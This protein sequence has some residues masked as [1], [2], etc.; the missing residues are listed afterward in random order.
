MYNAEWPLTTR[1]HICTACTHNRCWLSK[2]ERSVYKRTGMPHSLPTHWSSALCHLAISGEP[3][4][5]AWVTS[6]NSHNLKVWLR[7]IIDLMAIILWSPSC[8]ST[9][10]IKNQLEHN[11]AY[12]LSHPGP[13]GIWTRC[14]TQVLGLS[15]LAIRDMLVMAWVTIASCYHASC[16]WEVY[17]GIGIRG[18]MVLC[19]CVCVCIDCCCWSM[20]CK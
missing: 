4:V 9:K 19:L 16:A 13:R 3:T 14:S 6:L 17:T 8:Y 2:A 10:V 18:Y 12:S 5:H 7:R 1:A 15:A 11:Y 20:K